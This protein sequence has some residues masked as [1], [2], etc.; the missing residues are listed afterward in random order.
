MFI[1]SYSK[2]Q[3][4]INFNES[5]LNEFY[6][7][8][9]HLDDVRANSE[10]SKDL[11]PVKQL[12]DGLPQDNY[13]PEL[14]NELTAALADCIKHHEIIIESARKVESFISTLIF[15]K[16]LQ[17]TFQFCNILYTL[18]SV[19]DVGGFL[20]LIIYL[21]LTFLDIFQLCY[22]GETLKQQSLKV[23]DAIFHSSWHL[24]GGQFRRSVSIFLSNSN[25]PL[26]LTGGKFF[27]LDFAKMSA[28]SEYF[29]W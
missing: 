21:S 7:G 24:C 26:L 25:R 13:L 4:K 3:N 18:I 29:T 19:S 12:P 17:M 22:F 20:L 27:I 9:E 16:S 28:V 14:K 11:P 1:F 8:P 2:E 10:I 23:G 6:M 15:V 5:L